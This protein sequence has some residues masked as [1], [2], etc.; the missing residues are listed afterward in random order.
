MRRSASAASPRSTPTSS[1]PLT[2]RTRGEG[3]SGRAVM[4][5]ILVAVV[6][7][8]L[9]RLTKVAV[10]RSIPV[11][12]SRPLLG[13]LV[14]LTHVQN[15]G[16]AFSLGIGLGSFFLAFALVAVV[17]IAYAY[18][19]LPPD[20]Q[21]SRLALGMILGGAI[22]NALDRVLQGSVTDFVD[23]RWFPV[24]NTADSFITVGALIL[25]WRMVA[26]RG[27]AA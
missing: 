7:F 26:R 20:E 11:N 5:L 19:H 16:A 22:G 15:T 12:G 1:Q 24:F 23:F 8:V 9:D 13:G 4:F 27:D 6:V 25:A 10:V 18:R 2:P 17:G 21:W 3:R 14:Y